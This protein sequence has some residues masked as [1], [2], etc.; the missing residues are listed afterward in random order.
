MK[1]NV[2]VLYV[3]GKDIGSIA[4]REAVFNSLLNSLQAEGRTVVRDQR[5]TRGRTVTFDD[6]S[7]LMH[8]AYGITVSGHRLTHVYL[9]P[10]TL[11]IEGVDRY[12]REAVLPFI[13]ETPRTVDGTYLVEYDIAD[14]RRH[15]IFLADYDPDHG[16]SR[17]VYTPKK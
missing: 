14:D 1:K 6:D 5:D 17:S 15:R 7:K 12:L 4:K 9:D 2:M 13:L 16:L 8:Y 10:Q 11:S 3:A